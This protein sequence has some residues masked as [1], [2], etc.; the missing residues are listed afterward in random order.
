MRTGSGFY[1]AYEV[2]GVRVCRKHIAKVIDGATK[3]LPKGDRR[4]PDVGAVAALTQDRKNRQR[5]LT[6]DWLRAL[7][8]IGILDI[9][10][11]NI[12]LI[13]KATASNSPPG[14]KLVHLNPGADR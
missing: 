5:T 12:G 13:D 2:L 8:K 3:T 10:D 6:H 11:P 9:P 4:V 7:E 1:A 14:V